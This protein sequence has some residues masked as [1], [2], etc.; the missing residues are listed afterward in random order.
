[1]TA[2]SKMLDEGPDG[3]L[4]LAIAVQRGEWPHTMDA[5]VWASKFKELF[6]ESDEGLMLGWFANAIMAGYDTAQ[7]RQAKQN[8]DAF[9]KDYDPTDSLDH[10]TK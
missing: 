4:A 7:M 5:Q 8:K 9:W 2:T 6:P 3:E 1:M 10:K